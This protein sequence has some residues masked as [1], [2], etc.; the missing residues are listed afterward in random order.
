MDEIL[1]GKPD[2]TLD[3]S[4]EFGPN[5]TGTTNRGDNTMKVGIISIL[6]AL[7]LALPAFAGPADPCA[8]PTGVPDPD[9]DGYRDVCD[10]CDVIAN[11][12]QIDTDS[13]GFGNYC[14]CDFNDDLIANGADFLLFGA[15]FGQATV[16]PADPDCDMNS[17]GFING[18]DFLLFGGCFANGAPGTSCD[19]ALGI[20][21]PNP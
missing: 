12:L 1:L 8:D 18:A 7:L 4:A 9:A 11:P 6:A 16:P 13:D 5:A 21:C 20:P 15:C 14:D 2:K 17:D 19:W 10:N 3:S